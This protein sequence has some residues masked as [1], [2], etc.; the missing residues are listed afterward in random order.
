MADG[1]N[2]LL[3][4]SQSDTL[5]LTWE[6]LYSW[7]ESFIGA[8]RRLFILTVYRD[9]ALVGVAP[10]YT[11]SQTRWGFREREVRFLGTP[12][13]AS[14]YLDV[15]AKPGEEIAVAQQVYA[16]LWKEKAAWEM[17]V[18]RDIPSHSRFLLHFLE[19]IEEDGRPYQ[20]SP[21][22]FCPTVILP[23]SE[24]AFL[25]Q[26][27]PGRRRRTTQHYNLLEKQGPVKWHS[28]SG[29][30]VKPLLEEFRSFYS[31]CRTGVETDAKPLFSFLE[32]FASHSVDQ[33]WIYVEFLTVGDKK[34]A[35][36]LNF[37]YR[38]ILLFYLS[39][40][41]KA[42]VPRQVHIW[43]VLF[44]FEARQ[45]IAADLSIYDFLKG[46]EAYKFQWAT[47]GRRSL[48]LQVY[49][50]NGAALIRAIQNGAKTV[51]KVLLR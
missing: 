4:Q 47:S 42:A 35:G 45:A 27:S 34:I 33:P 50:K 26:Q 41:D 3:V 28:G 12:E 40:I 15:F 22:A 49:G 1:W 37:R 6:W 32:R 48:T 14:D 5:F 51:G 11:H 7:A 46:S 39:A 24:E 20:L 18:L 21:A 16:H 43:S 9:N 29:A 25:K 13:A 36:K 31:H 8:D 17:L 2:A 38:N 30:D 10:W 19:Q 44:A 23:E